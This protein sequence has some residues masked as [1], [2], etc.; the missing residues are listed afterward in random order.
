MQ[1]KQKHKIIT[2]NIQQNQEELSQQNVFYSQQQPLRKPTLQISI[3]TPAQFHKICFQCQ[4][5][6]PYGPAN[7][8]NQSFNNAF[9]LF[10][11]GQ[12]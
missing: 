1:I 11:N 4:I 8:N 2:K 9:I 10:R 7:L 12:G 5:T 6:F 3:S